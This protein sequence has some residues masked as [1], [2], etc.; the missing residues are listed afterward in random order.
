MVLAHVSLEDDLS[1]LLGW[2]VKELLVLETNL[3][4]ESA[5]NFAPAARGAIVLAYAHW[6]GFFN[7]ATD[8]L[9]QRLETSHLP[10]VLGR[11]LSRL[12]AMRAELDRLSSKRVRDDD[13]VKFVLCHSAAEFVPDALDSKVVKSR[14]N[15]D[16]GRLALAFD[17]YGVSSPALNEQRIFIQHQLVGLR[18][19]IAHGTD[20]KLKRSFVALHL[21]KTRHVLVDL[22]DYF[23]V[24]ESCFSN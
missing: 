1:A 9:F 21:S 10:R 22:S 20:P 7:D 5:S 3:P 24:V 16:W 15:L 11:P 6:E 19:A 23:T 12:F 13:I 8:A 14:S 17:V 4:P 2:R 18:H